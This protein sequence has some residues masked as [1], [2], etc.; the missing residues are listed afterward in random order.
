MRSVHFALPR[1]LPRALSRGI[2]KLWLNDQ[3]HF[4]QYE[5]LLH[6]VCELPDL[7][8]LECNAS[9]GSLP[10]ELPRR[11]PRTD[12]NKLR[13]CTVTPPGTSGWVDAMLEIALYMSVY[14]AASFFSEAEVV[15]ILAV[16]NGLQ[17]H[18]PI[19]LCYSHDPQHRSRTLDFVD[20]AD[21]ENLSFLTLHILRDGESHV[22]TTLNV[23]VDCSYSHSDEEPEEDSG[24]IYWDDWKQTDADAEFRESTAPLRHTHFV[25]GFADRRQLKHFVKTVLE[26]DP[27]A[28]FRD[29]TLRYGI[30]DENAVVEAGA[31]DRFGRPAQGAWRQASL[32]SEELTGE[33]RRRLPELYS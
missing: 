4:R 1:S 20:D 5:D 2:K 24:H 31:K 29:A 19:A 25:L 7:E 30:W 13:A 18:V 27:P 28:I 33:P 12:R 23:G 3:T 16:L 32:D 21:F 26:E 10:T 8:M 17:T 22:H 11:R 9:F 14:D 15:P 6:L